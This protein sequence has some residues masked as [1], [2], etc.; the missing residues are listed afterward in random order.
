MENYQKE[1]QKL[2]GGDA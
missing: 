2:A 1:M